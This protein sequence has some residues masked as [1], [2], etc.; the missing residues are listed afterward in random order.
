M[1]ITCEHT[2]YLSFLVRHHIIL[3]CKRYAKKVRKFKTKIASQQ[4][5]EYK[6]TYC[7][8]YQFLA[9]S[10]YWDCILGVLFDVLDVLFGVLGVLFGLLGVLFGVFGV[11]VGVLGVFFGVL[12]VFILWINFPKSSPFRVFCG[13]RYAGL[14]KVHHR[15]LWRLWQLWGMHVKLWV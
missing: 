10:F 11:L 7:K 15:R 3:A 9:Y 14:K 12:N 2:S 4:N 8:L 1:C 13:K 6:F 5:R